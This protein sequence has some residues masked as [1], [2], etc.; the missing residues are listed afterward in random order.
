MP[1]VTTMANTSSPLAMSLPTPTVTSPGSVLHSVNSKRGPP[2]MQC[3]AVMSQ[4]A[5]FKA[6]R[7]VTSQAVEQLLDVIDEVM[8]EL[9]WEESSKEANS[10]EEVHEIGEE[11]QELPNN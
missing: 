8:E 2:Q 7:P 11:F 10:M 9:Q 1:V 4:G 6:N 5:R 3:Q